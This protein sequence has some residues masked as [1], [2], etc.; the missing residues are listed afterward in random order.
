MLAWSG[1]LVGGAVLAGAGLVSQSKE[2]KRHPCHLEAE[3][4]DLKW[5]ER[6]RH[7]AQERLDGVL[8][9]MRGNKRRSD[10]PHLEQRAAS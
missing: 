7:Q 4:F 8:A 2:A 1:H 3:V 6:Y 5:I 10:H 9:E